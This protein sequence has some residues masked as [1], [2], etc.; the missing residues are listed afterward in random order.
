M[1]SNVLSEIESFEEGRYDNELR[2]NAFIGSKTGEYIDL[3]DAVIKTPEEYI[4]LWVKGLKSAYKDSINTGR[5][6]RHQRIYSLLTGDFPNF[7]KY[8]RL[9]LEGSFLKHYEEHYKAKPKIDESEYWFGNNG[10]EFG[11]LVT[12]RFKNGE[13]ENDKSEVRH[14]S[15]PYWT[16][17]HALETGFVYMKEDRKRTFSTVA[18]YLQFFRDIV[19]RTKS[20]YQLELA[21]ASIR[22]VESHE[23]PNEVP[24]LIP[25]VRYDPLKKTQ[26]QA[27]FLD[28][29]PVD[30]AKVWRGNFPL[31]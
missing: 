21:D 2:L 24:L 5:D 25:E 30:N 28:H 22:Y 29:Q 14:F 26:I 3:K 15:H 4:S 20:K 17:A 10:D 23:I 27:G 12:P 1:L 9:F 8:F 7:R 6:P 18:N 11:I 31:E 19:R 16:I 13:W